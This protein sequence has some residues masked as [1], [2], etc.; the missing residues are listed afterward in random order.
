MNINEFR[1]ISANERAVVGV[2]TKTGD[3]RAESGTFLGRT[4]RRVKE[5]FGQAQTAKGPA[6]NR[7]LQ[8][9]AHRQSGYGHAEIDRA[10]DLLTNDAKEGKP[11]TGRKISEVLDEIDSMSSPTR[12]INRR[13]T[14]YFNPGREAHDSLP[15]TRSEGTAQHQAHAPE[16][17]SDTATQEAHTQSTQEG[18]PTQAAT[19]E[20]DRKEQPKALRKAL[21]E[22]TLPKEVERGLKSQIKNGSISTGTALAREGNSALSQWVGENRIGRWYVEA[23]GNKEAKREAQRSGAI[24]VPSKIMQTVTKAIN[25]SPALRNYENVKVYARALIAAEVRDASGA[26]PNA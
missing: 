20:S 9:I 8:A 12:R 24:E 3:V 17:T 1:N 14:N 18:T 19:P 7:F 23:L 25:E 15:S 6:H 22:A 2:D 11:L 26:R 5:L 21:S 16:H 4:V 13:V 10:R